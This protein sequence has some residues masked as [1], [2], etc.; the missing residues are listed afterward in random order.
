MIPS[1]SLAANIWTSVNPQA[2]GV[3]F[4]SWGSLSH[5][6]M[7]NDAGVGDTFGGA[8][9]GTYRTAT[10]SIY[11]NTILRMPAKHQNYSYTLKFQGPRL[12]C[13]DVTNQTLFDQ[14]NPRARE[15]SSRSREVQTWYNA[16][17]EERSFDIHFYTPKGNFT[18]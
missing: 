4:I 12:R 8:T 13:G 7:A 3:P 6:Q 18:C 2:E 16:T 10:A 17:S 11:S 9:Q 15:C 1:A 5:H 14:L